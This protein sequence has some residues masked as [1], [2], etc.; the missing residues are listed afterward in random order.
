MVSIEDGAIPDADALGDPSNDPFFGTMWGGDYDT[1]DPS[2]SDNNGDEYEYQD[3][4]NNPDSPQYDDPELDFGDAS[5]PTD[6]PTESDSNS[7]LL[8]TAGVGVA[9]LL[10]GVVVAG[11]AVLGGD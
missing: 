3:P 11:V 9:G 6:A 5:D 10:V 2:G 8:A 7:G 1:V 4:T